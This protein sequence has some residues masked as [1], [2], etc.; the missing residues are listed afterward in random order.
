[1]RLILVKW[2]IQV[3]EK[4]KVNSETLHICVQL[5]DHMLI[6]E[7]G[8]INKANFQLLGIASL[9]VAAK[10]NEIHTPEAEK[11]IYVCDGL[12]KLPNLF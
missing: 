1:M 9:F 8:S 4:F 10:Y 11:Y 6:F 7:G 3:G 2:L 12:Y 5:V